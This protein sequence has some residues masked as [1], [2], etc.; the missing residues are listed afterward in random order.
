MRKDARIFVAGHTGLIG[1]AMIRRLGIQ[2]FTNLITRSREQLDLLR[3]GC[4]D[5]FFDETRPDYVLLAAGRT[6]GVVE[7]NTYPAILMEENLAI[8]LNVLKAAR[9]SGVEKLILFGSSCMYPRECSQPMTEDDLLTGKLEPTSLP[10]AISKFAG[11]YLCLAYNKQDGKNSFIPVIPNSAY[12][13]NDNFDPHS[14]H[15]LSALIFRFHE[16]KS[17]GAASLCMLMILPMLV[18]IYCNKTS[19]GWIVL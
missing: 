4:V 15:V 2:D 12:G 17:I 7:N 3:A 19:L 5:E 8:Q 6:G 18:C 14:A 16:A 1:S 13:P 10:Y 9:K 11:V